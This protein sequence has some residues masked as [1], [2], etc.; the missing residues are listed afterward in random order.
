M[1]PMSQ[2]GAA[3]SWG[4]LHRTSWTSCVMLDLSGCPVGWNSSRALRSTELCAPMEAGQIIKPAVLDLAVEKGHRGP[5]KEKFFKTA[6]NIKSL[7]LCS[8][9][10]SY[11]SRICHVF[12]KLLRFRI[13]AIS[14][15][16]GVCGARAAKAV[17]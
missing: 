6:S 7:E 13:T 2:R 9:P 16:Q 12:Q 4:T 15:Q 1:G 5:R 3:V 14:C 8:Y 11:Q 17:S 10:P